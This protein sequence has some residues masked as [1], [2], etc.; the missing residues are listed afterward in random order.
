MLEHVEAPIPEVGRGDALIEIHAASVNPVDWKIRQGLLKEFFR[1]TLP[2]VP[3]R[4]ASG[5]VIH[6][7]PEVTNVKVGEEVCFIAGGSAGG[8]YAELA[9]VDAR[10]LVRKPPRLTHV[11]AAAFPLVG[12]TAWIALV[13]TAVVGPGMNVLVH[14]GAGGVGGMAVQLAKYKGADVTATCRASNID[15]VLGLGAGSVVA[16]DKEDFS[17]VLKDYDV[18]FDSIGGEV[19][20]HSYRV[21]KPGGTIVYLI[22]APIEDLSDQFDVTTK[23]AP[24]RDDASVL[25]SVAKLVESG[26]IQPQVWKVLPLS[27]AVQAH[28]LSEAGHARGKIVLQVR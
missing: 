10:V 8:T 13:E 19:H 6:V 24:V 4:D 27:E 9:T 7:G 2:A 26:A 18:V 28:R 23:Q 14:G 3:G 11:E 20:R 5:V 17:A 12:V 21:L 15:Y 16:Y 25:K 1:W 22:A